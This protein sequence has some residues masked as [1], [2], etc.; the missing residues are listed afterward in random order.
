MKTIIRK[1]APKR[2]TKTITPHNNNNGWTPVAY[3]WK[4]SK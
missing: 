4:R 1:V 3:E 2:S